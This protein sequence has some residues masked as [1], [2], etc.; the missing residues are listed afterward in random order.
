MPRV[1]P[2]AIRIATMDDLPFL[3]ALQK[4]YHKQLG[5]F[6]RAQMEGYIEMGAV[7]IAVGAT[8]AS[9]CGAAANDS[10]LRVDRDA[11]VAPTGYIISRDRYLKRDE[12]GVIYQLCVAPGHQRGLIGASLVKEVFERS[13]YGCKLYCCWCA[14]DLDANYFWQS[15]GFLPI[16]FRAGSTGKRRVH[17]FWQRRIDRLHSVTPSPN[18]SVTPA[19]FWYPCQTNAGAIRED[20]LVFPIPPGTHWSEVQAVVVPTERR[21]LGVGGRE[22]EEKTK[23]LPSPTRNPKPEPRDPTGVIS[24]GGL[25]FAVNGAGGSA[26]GSEA[27]ARREVG[28][29]KK[30]PTTHH[31][32]PTAAKPRVKIDPKLSAAARHLRDCWMERANDRLLIAPKGK[33]DLS[34]ALGV[35][36]EAKPLP[37]PHA[38]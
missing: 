12:L 4:Q 20:R 36:V 24:S 38:A 11:G 32:R 29:G 5:F 16:A 2:I 21:G 13:A 17:I 6:P 14:Q 37:Q 33:Y 25:R 9:R 15:M 10:T 27:Q 3:D 18:H 28:G 34:R 30:R 23:R 1:G 31:P 19:S 22:L 8:P 26:F 35:R 7:L